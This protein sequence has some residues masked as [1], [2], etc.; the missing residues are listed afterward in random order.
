MGKI[1][2][3]AE[4]KEQRPVDKEENA[5]D[6]LSSEDKPSRMHVILFCSFFFQHVAQLKWL[7]L[8]TLFFKG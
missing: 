7:L 6:V 5:K 3:C 1:K 2:K 8:T 4:C